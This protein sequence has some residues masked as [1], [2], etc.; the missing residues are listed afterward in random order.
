MW[1]CRKFKGAALVAAIIS[2]AVISVLGLGVTKIYS[3]ALTAMSFSK[4][5]TRA[6]QYAK[7]QAGLIRT[8]EYAMLQDVAK[9]DITGTNFKYQ[10]TKGAETAYN[11]EINQRKMLVSIYHKD[12][13]VPIYTLD[14]VR[15]SQDMNQGPKGDKGDKGDPG[16]PGPQGIQGIQGPKG[17]TGATGATGAQ[18]PKGDKGESAAKAYVTETWHEGTEWYRVW[19]DGWIEQGGRYPAWSGNPTITLSFKKTFSNSNYG[20]ITHTMGTAASEYDTITTKSRTKSDITLILF[21]SNRSGFDYY[22]Y[23]Y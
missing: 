22:C 20:F 11:S 10:I 14:V 1:K 13:S 8:T 18:G 3:S 19:S 7:A 2:A 9:T 16:E 12:E 6:E 17:D 23:G 21:T 4:V 5:V 15:Y